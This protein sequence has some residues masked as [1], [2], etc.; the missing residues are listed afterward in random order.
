MEIL[1]VLI[2][3]IPIALIIRWAVLRYNGDDGTRW[4]H[5]AMRDH[6]K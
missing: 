5:E 6:W 3:A 4:D 2:I 1:L